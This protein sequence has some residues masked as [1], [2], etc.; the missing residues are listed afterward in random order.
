MDKPER[1]HRP[2]PARTEPIRDF[3]SY[4]RTV[5][6]GGAPRPAASADPDLTDR[7]VAHGVKLGYSVIDE[8]I[9][10]G[11]KLAERLRQIPGKPDAMPGVEVDTLIE[12]ALNVY[13]DMGALAIAAVETLVRNPVLQSTV[14]RARPGNGA[15]QQAGPASGGGSAFGFELSSSRRTQVKLDIKPQAVMV[16]PVVHALHAANPDLPPLTGVRFHFDTATSMPVLQIDVAD[17]QPAGT[18]R[19]VVVDS[20]TDEPC[21]TLSVR[22]LPS[23]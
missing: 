3:S 4:M 19:G 11:E 1:L 18:Y 13:K 22:V 8:Q 23:A 6:L 21:G 12:R 2:D 5:G 7:A 10:Q 16:M 17:S 15:A 14:A 9:R 20:A